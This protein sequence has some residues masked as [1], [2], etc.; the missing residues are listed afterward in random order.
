MQQLLDDI[1]HFHTV[2]RDQHAT[3]LIEAFVDFSTQGTWHQ[4]RRVFEEDII[5]VV[6][7]L[8]ADFQGIAKPLRGDQAGLRPFAL[9]DGV[10]NQC[11][12]V[13]GG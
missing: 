7:L 11:S 3:G 13:D 8:P 4:R 1:E 6:A 12:A 5:D 2:E 9:D 10:G